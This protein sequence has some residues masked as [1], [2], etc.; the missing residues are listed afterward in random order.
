[1]LWKQLG[2]VL[3]TLVCGIGM[4]VFCA[5]IAALSWTHFHGTPRNSFID[6]DGVAF[7][8]ICGAA[9]FGAGI[10][11]CIWGILTYERGR[12]VAEQV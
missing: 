11:S 4:C 7:A 3:L 9:G 10:T 1:M 2:Y 6:F 5:S 12:R 8:G